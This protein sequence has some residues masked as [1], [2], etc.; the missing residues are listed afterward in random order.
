[1]A[2]DG[3]AAV[4]A[5][6]AD[7]AL[8]SNS[9]PEQ[10]FEVVQFA[11][12]KPKK[13]QLK[14][15]AMGLTVFDGPK[16]FESCVYQTIANFEAKAVPGGTPVLLVEAPAKGKKKLQKRNYRSAECE[17]IADLMRLHRG[18]QARIKR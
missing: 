17:A 15:G 9:V 4:A 8:R 13:V 11:P 14:V 2:M 1:M 18:V 16:L 3:V 10:V 12:G 7:E 6:A 5:L